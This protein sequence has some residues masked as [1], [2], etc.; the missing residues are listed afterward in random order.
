MHPAKSKKKI[1]TLTQ[2]L[3]KKLRYLLSA[4]LLAATWVATSAQ[5]YT[6]N[7]DWDQSDGSIIYDGSKVAFYSAANRGG[8][9]NG[10]SN[11]T[12]EL[13]GDGAYT[14]VAT[15][16]NAEDGNP[17]WF[18]QQNSTGKYV[19]KNHIGGYMLGG[20]GTYF[21]LTESIDDA[22]GFTILP[23]HPIELEGMEGATPRNI[24]SDADQDLDGYAWVIC[25]EHVLETWTDP[26]TDVKSDSAIYTYLGAR[27]YPMLSTWYDTNCWWIY[28]LAGATGVELIEAVYNDIAANC[29]PYGLSAGIDPGCYGETEIADYT[30]VYNEVTDQLENYT[31]NEEQTTDLV[32][33]LK[34]AKEAL[35]ASLVKFEAGK[36]YMFGSN[37]NYGIGMYL[38]WSGAAW[39][40]GTPADPSAVNVNDASY[41]FFAEDAGEDE[42]GT[43]LYKLKNFDSNTYITSNYSGNNVVPGGTAATLEISLQTGSSSVKNAYNI[44]DT[45]EN[46][47]SGGIL[48]HASGTHQLATA[49]METLKQA[50]FTI[51]TVP[52]DEVAALEEELR[53]AK[54]NADLAKILGLSKALLNSTKIYKP[55]ADCTLDGNTESMGLVTAAD[56][57]SS[58]A[59]H[60]A[61]N[62]ASP[63]GSGLAGL[64]DNDVTTYFHSA[65]QNAP[66]ATHFIDANLNQQIDG[67]SL[68]L[69]RRVHNNQ[70]PAPVM[71]EVYASNDSIDWVN[72]G[73]LSVQYDYDHVAAA[74]DTIL[75]LYP[76]SVITRAGFVGVGALPFNASYQYVRLAVPASYT[77]GGNSAFFYL[78]ELRYYAG[79]DYDAAASLYEKAPQAERTAF[80]E[81]LA[82][83]DAE[84]AAGNASQATIDALQAAYDALLKVIPSTAD[85]HSMVE[86]YTKLVGSAEEG[87]GIGFYT[88]GSKAAF[89][90]VIDKIANAIDEN[91]SAAQIAEAEAELRAAYHTFQSGFQ[92]PEEGKLYA[93]RPMAKE[94]AYNNSGEQ[95]SKCGQYLTSTEL[96]PG[97]WANGEGYNIAPGSTF[98]EGREYDDFDLSSSYTSLWTFEYNA[99]G[100]SVYIRNAATGFYLSNPKTSATPYPFAMSSFENLNEDNV[101]G[102][103]NIVFT[104]ADG[105][106]LCT[107]NT[108]ALVN[109]AAAG[110]INSAFRI[111]EIEGSDIITHKT[112]GTVEIMSLPYTVYAFIAD[113][114]MLEILGTRTDAATNKKYVVL[115]PINDDVVEAGEPFIFWPNEAGQTTVNFDL[116]DAVGNPL[117]GI[118]PKLSLEGKSANG[119]IGVVN[120]S[121]WILPSVGKIE[122]KVVKATKYELLVNSHSGYITNDQLDNE[123]EASEYELLLEGEINVSDIES[124]LAAGPKSSGVY[125]IDGRFAGKSVKALPA[126]IYV[127]NG[128]KI[129][130]K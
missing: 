81:A 84:Y 18:L 126:G 112:K 56:R 128:K 8:Y 123:V 127:V 109:E 35:D 50:L 58:N 74:H 78:S 79:A 44:I 47:P 85:L 61:L 41:Y 110:N 49:Y 45:D 12:A 106:V 86:N 93:I 33:R 111:E 72:Q 64:L 6:P 83:A 5:S 65:W 63:D 103:N 80:E 114:E 4:F 1:H 75:A 87:I 92:V 24:S 34:A 2:I 57:L 115:G 42:A 36:Y 30:A 54:L 60:N 23:N 68:K 89:E 96:Y 129:L 31:Y 32:A 46:A 27:G 25:S 108:L 82:V 116:T 15:G 21:Q 100:D 22:L 104:L 52:N 118:A 73:A 3:M 125:S 55:A 39:N 67:L 121:I 62:P 66:S 94:I 70:D 76:D 16:R 11:L 99:T 97:K 120:G 102:K 28:P 124:V 29:S 113:G 14:I 88:E 130:V 105:S 40:F 122:N 37:A 13:T 95:V 59:D 77:Q 7:V 19:K 91:W 9:L 43:K 71:F 90:A 107:N 51:K 38:R 69:A 10:E 53:L 117:G 119:M 101:Q 98:K 48:S 17:L 26:I 20:T